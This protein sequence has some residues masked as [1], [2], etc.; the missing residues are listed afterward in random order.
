MKIIPLLFLSLIA[1]SL[2]AHA[3]KYNCT[4]HLENVAYT[5]RFI[6]LSEQLRPYLNR[7]DHGLQ[8]KTLVFIGFDYENLNIV[9]N[10]I[11]GVLNDEG[12][13]TTKPLNK[14]EL[15]DFLQNVFPVL[16]RLSGVMPKI[17]L[18]SNQQPK[19]FYTKSRDLVR[20]LL[21][22]QVEAKDYLSDEDSELLKSQYNQRTIN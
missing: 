10:M 13:V 5:D 18:N 9:L 14:K 17:F 4:I 6:E 16:S 21:R 22:S 3:E 20:R 19:V 8:N 1:L 2:S 7:I 12:K 15:E 11:R